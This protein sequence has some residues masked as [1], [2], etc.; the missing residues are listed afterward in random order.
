MFLM[1]FSKIIGILFQMEW[2]RIKYFKMDVFVAFTSKLMYLLINILF[3][4]SLIH[5][6]YSLPGWTYK[7]IL[8][9]IAFSELFYGLNTSVFSMASRFWQYIY[10]G[11]LDVALTRPMDP[12]TR[13]ILLNI[14]YIELFFT[15]IE[16]IVLLTISG[17]SIRPIQLFLGV[18]FTIWANIILAIIRSCMS[19]LAF[20]HG[21]MEA[22]SEISD[23]MT[24]FNKYPLV[25]MPPTLVTAF[26]VILP[27]FFFSTMSAQVMNDMVDIKNILISILEIIVSTVMWFV[28]NAYLWNKGLRR[29]EG[30]NG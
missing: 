14:D 18:M 16:F 8:V 13:F 20:W 22:I 2:K 25:I 17:V 5:I 11:N 4:Y 9:F 29:Y 15:L 30:I 27:F 19:Y 10:S 3:W 21:K 6:G 1:K 26:K 24:S 28:I 7:N 23:A 12:R